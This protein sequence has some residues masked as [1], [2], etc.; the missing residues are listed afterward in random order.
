MSYAS[1]VTVI[2]PEETFDFRIYMNNILNY[3]GYKFFQ[4]SYDI[5][6]PVEETRLSVNHDFWGTTIT[7]AGY[8]ILYVGLMLIMFVKNNPIESDEVG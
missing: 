2:D 6:G 8:M 1:E 5:S 4:S 7:Y 3:K